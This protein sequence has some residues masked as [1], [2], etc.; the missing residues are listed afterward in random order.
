MPQPQ[1]RLLV[2]DDNRMNRLKLAYNLEQQGH[3]VTLAENGQ[4]AL[5]LLQSQPFD[6]VLL[7]MLMPGID[8]FQVLQQLKGDSRLRDLPVIVISALDEM[9]CVV[10]CIEMGAEDYLL[11]PFDPVLLRAR[12]SA[13]LEKKRLRDLEVDYLQNVARV[14]TAAAALEAGTFDPDH[15]ANV[16]A[17]TDELGQFV[18]VFQR[19]AREVYT[20]EQHLRRQVQELRIEI[21]RARQASQVSEITGTDYFQQL[22]NKAQDL[23][24]ELAEGEE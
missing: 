12:I 21:D 8:G 22:R 24:A 18:R 10:K 11:K 7:D 2:V 16:A 6:L 19:M 20:R 17:R 9:E 23:R 4:Q 14:T 5:A 15:L 1:G 3:A 13:G